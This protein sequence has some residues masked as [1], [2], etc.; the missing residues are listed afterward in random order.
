MEEDEEE[1]VGEVGEVGEES[2]DVQLDRL[3]RDEGGTSDETEVYV[4]EKN[5]S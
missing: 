4:P 5:T 1:I 3:N 2:K